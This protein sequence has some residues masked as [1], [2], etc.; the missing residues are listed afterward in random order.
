MI[1]PDSQYDHNQEPFKEI[2]R[3]WR[4]AANQIGLDFGIYVSV[5][6]SSTE[7]YYVNRIYF[8]WDKREFESLSELKR[9]LAMK[10]FL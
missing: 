5:A 9:V 1:L 8:K 2:Y 6:W 3:V 7:G 10:A 4:N